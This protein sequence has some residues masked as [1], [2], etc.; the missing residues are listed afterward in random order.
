MKI[1][2]LTHLPHSYNYRRF[3]EAGTARGHEM[4]FIPLANC[5]MNISSTSPEVY[6]KS[7]DTCKGLDAVIPYFSLKHNFYGTA[8]LR[9][10]EM[11][12]VYTLN[13]SLA[14]TWSRDKLRAMQLLARKH[15]PLPITGFADSP[16]ESEKLIDVVGGAPLI[17]RL[18]D[19]L[20][21]RGTVFA[22]THQA[23]LSV[24]NAFKQL[25]TNI[26]VQEYIKEAEGIDIR[27][28]IV[29]NKVIT[30]IQREIASSHFHLSRQHR[31]VE[32]KL[33]KITVAERKIVVET[34]KAMKLNL[35]CIDLIRS[36][37]GPLILD[38]DPSPNIESLEK[39]T[40]IDICASIIQFIEENVKKNH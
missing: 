1:A 27:C 18:L 30:A 15:L 32:S 9:Q 37:R 29:G 31:T 22:E 2:L 25:K 19:G 21:G 5:Y 28:L 14:I 33:V 8:V 7:G 36:K 12:G 23:A 17:V 39:A 26:L 40:K 35:G 20:E 34:A 16:E 3:M 4:R 11:M 38:I 24:I 6:Y 10:L 13:S